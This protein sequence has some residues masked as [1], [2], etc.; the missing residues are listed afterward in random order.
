MKSI[1]LTLTKRAYRRTNKQ[2]AALAEIVQ[3]VS[4]A[5]NVVEDST[6]WRSALRRARRIARRAL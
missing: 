2:K 3:V 6:V 1:R 4:D 5:L